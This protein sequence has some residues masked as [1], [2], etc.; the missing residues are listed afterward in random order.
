AR[1]QKLGVKDIALVRLEQVFPFPEKHVASILKKYRNNMLTLWVQEEPENMGA[2]YYIRNSMKNTEILPVTRQPSGS[3]A[4]GLYK[5]HEISQAEIIDKVFREC[6]CE[7]QYVYCGLQCVIGS[8]RKEILKQHFYFDK[9]QP[10]PQ[11]T[12]A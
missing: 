11:K 6:T 12:K 10:K 5:L 4:T 2:W 9:E 1:K 8:S 3:P 7:L